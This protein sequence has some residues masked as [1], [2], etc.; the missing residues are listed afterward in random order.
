MPLKELQ[1]PLPI[2]GLELYQMGV[3]IMAKK[4]HDNYK[5]IMDSDLIVFGALLS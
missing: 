5:K 4:D 3:H 1:L 2:I